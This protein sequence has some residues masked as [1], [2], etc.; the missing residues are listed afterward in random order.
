MATVLV[1]ASN[2][3]APISSTGALEYQILDSDARHL[4][5]TNAVCDFG[6]L[7]STSANQR[8]QHDF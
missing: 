2:K 3:K 1:D 5:V 8:V 6:I 4:V 7:R